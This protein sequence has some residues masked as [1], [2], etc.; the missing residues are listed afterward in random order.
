M[1]EYVALDVSLRSTSVHIVDQQG[2]CL[3]RGTCPTDVAALADTIRRHAPAVE[4]VGLE[5]GQLATWLCHGLTKAGLP[6]VCMDARQAKAAL[7]CRI[8]KT[9]ANDA[10]GLAQLLRTG[11]FRQVRVKSEGTMLV[12]TLLSARRQLVRTGLDLANQIRGLLKIFGLLLPRGGGRAF[13]AAVRERLAGHGQL[14]TVI[15][16]LLQAW[17]A[18]R[19]QV[20]AL[21]RQACAVAK[22]D[23]R[24]RLLLT[25]PGVGTIT[26]LAYVAAVERPGE[27]RN[28]RAVGAWVGLTP[29]RYQSGQVDYSGRISRQGD[30]HLRTCLYEA[31]NTVLTRSRADS[32]LKRWGL[33]LKARL[34]H[35]RAVVAVARKLAVVLHAMW[36]KEEPFETDAAVA[37][38]RAADVGASLRP[39]AELPSLPGRRRDHRATLAAAVTDRDHE[40][41]RDPVPDTIVRLAARQTAE[42]TPSPAEHSLSFKTA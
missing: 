39:T 5:T 25:A 8:N 19:E 23:A 37:A 6:V 29:A 41:E 14:A 30:V 28:A 9:D 20:L 35:R 22:R 15:T 34:G 18:V 11:F 4:R 40:T 13:E 16:P 1:A 31:A 10:E 32:A 3:W 17:R 2:R 12:R 38:A 24:C 27:F 26:A 36:S 21:D 33:G 7:S 42:T